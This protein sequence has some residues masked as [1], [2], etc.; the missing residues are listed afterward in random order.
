MSYASVHISISE[1]NFKKN[2]MT[3]GSEKYIVH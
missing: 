1:A 2:P 3:Y